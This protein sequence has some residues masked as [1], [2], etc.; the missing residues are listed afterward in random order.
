VITTH[1][2]NRIVQVFY[3]YSRRM[4]VYDRR[5]RGLYPVSSLADARRYFAS[6]PR[7]QCPP[8]RSFVWGLHISRLLPFA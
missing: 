4:V 5:R 6:S 2:Y 3:A 1:I 7:L 8:Q